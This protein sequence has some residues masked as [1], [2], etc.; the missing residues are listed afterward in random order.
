MA[1]DTDKPLFVIS[2][3]AELA[4][5][6][7]QTLRQYDRQGLVR[8]SRAPGR[9]R[10]YSQRDVQKLRHVQQLSQD[11]VSLQGIKRIIELESQ[12]AALQHRLTELTRERDE[13]LEQ[14]ESDQSVFAATASG[15]IVRLPRGRR[16]LPSERPG[17]S[18]SRALMLYRPSDGQGRAS[19]T[20]RQRC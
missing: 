3:A 15:E 11:G 16:R 1:L 4:S 18:S 20:Q 13:A 7:P 10:R 14:V 19:A 12:V 8:P 2:V 9:A 5:M 17:V 6:H